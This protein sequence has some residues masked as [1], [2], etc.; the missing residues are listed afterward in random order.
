MFSQAVRLRFKTSLGILSRFSLILK[1]KLLHSWDVICDKT[2]GLSV[3][4]IL[5]LCEFY[6]FINV[7]LCCLCTYLESLHIVYN[8][9]YIHGFFQSRPWTI[10]HSSFCLTFAFS[11][12][13]NPRNLYSRQICDSDIGS[14]MLPL[15]KKRFVSHSFI[16]LILAVCVIL[17]ENLTWKKFWKL[18]GQFPNRTISGPSIKFFTW[19]LENA[20]AIP[21]FIHIAEC[22]SRKI[23]QE[24]DP[25]KRASLLL[26]TG[27][28]RVWISL[29]FYFTSTEVFF[30]IQELG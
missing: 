8:I 15:S 24:L 29:L 9:H 17:W 27:H 25:K 28:V 10:N 30:L 20:M 2:A 18:N 13:L 1:F 5:S 3:V 16:F 6:L 14:I 12:N 22:R 26:R 11:L 7:L 23:S 4:K 21:S 19:Y